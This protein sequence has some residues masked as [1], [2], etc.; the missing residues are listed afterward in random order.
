M[1]VKNAY[2]VGCKTIPIYKITI[3]FSKHSNISYVILLILLSGDIE[4][5]PGPDSWTSI[6]Q[7]DFCNFLRVAIY[8]VFEEIDLLP[9]PDENN[10]ALVGVKARFIEL[11]TFYGEYYQAH[12]MEL[13]PLQKNIKAFT[14]TMKEW[15]RNIFF[16]QIGK[17][18]ITR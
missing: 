14:G 11:K 8:M 13:K 4:T 12:L 5:N 9:N 10:N 18:W 7:P 15:G 6:R 1:S 2:N 16:P 17:N 3:V